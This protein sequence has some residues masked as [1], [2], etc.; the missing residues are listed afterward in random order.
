MGM[1]VGHLLCPRG[2]LAEEVLSRGI[3]GGGAL[4]LHELGVLLDDRAEQRLAPRVQSAQ[5]GLH[6]GEGLSEGGEGLDGEPLWTPLGGEGG[7]GELIARA[8]AVCHL[9]SRAER[10]RRVHL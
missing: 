9:T 10:R 5:A 4:G 6:L 2:Q 7:V 8:L 1:Q 3:R